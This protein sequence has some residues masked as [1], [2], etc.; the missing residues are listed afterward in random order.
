MTRRGFTLIELLVVIAIIAILAAILFPVFARA[1]EKARQSSCQS[2]EKQM[3]LGV[4]MYTQDY[5][6]QFPPTYYAPAGSLALRWCDLIAPYLKNTQIMKCPSDAGVA[7]VWGNGTGPSSYMANYFM[8]GGGGVSMAS[9]VAPAGTVY[10]CDGGAYG[11]DAGVAMPVNPKSGCWILVD[12]GFPNTAVADAVGN[13]NGDWGA[14]NPRHSEVVNV[15]FVDGHVKSLK[16]S[17]WYYKSTPW[18]NPAVG[19]S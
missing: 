15:G 14:P 8:G 10:L 19:G 12:T 9:V 4:M 16:S 17:A 18:D 13:A 3:M 1:R 7:Y 11:N 6:E 2:N 5:D